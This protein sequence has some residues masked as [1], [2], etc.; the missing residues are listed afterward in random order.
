MS[1]L[2]IALVGSACIPRDT[3]LIVLND[4]QTNSEAIRRGHW[5]EGFNAV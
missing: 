4:E 1:G 3:S 5:L 2:L